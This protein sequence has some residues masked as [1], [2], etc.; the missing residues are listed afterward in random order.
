MAVQQQHIEA[1]FRRDAKN[2]F[3]AVSATSRGHTATLIS[4]FN[5]QQ[6]VSY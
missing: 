3:A 5:F 2:G 6:G 4:G 1:C